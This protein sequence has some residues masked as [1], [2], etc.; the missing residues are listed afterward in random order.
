MNEAAEKA[1]STFFTQYP[2]VVS[3]EDLSHMLGICK[4]NA[5]SLVKNGTIRGVKIGR[6]W[7]IPKRSVYLYLEDKMVG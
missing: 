1:Y 7:R 5:Y 4:V 3:V 2:D 6:V